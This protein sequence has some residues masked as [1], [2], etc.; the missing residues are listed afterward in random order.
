MADLDV[1]TQKVSSDF[2][3]ADFKRPADSRLANE[4]LAK[5]GMD[6]MRPLKSVIAEYLDNDK[7]NKVTVI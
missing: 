2:F 7:H 6:I 5:S 1:K 3:P 4:K